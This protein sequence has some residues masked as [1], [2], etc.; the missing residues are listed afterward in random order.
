MRKTIGGQL[1]HERKNKKTSRFIW[2]SYASSSG[3]EDFVPLLPR[4]G[5]TEIVIKES[6]V[7]V[8]LGTI[9]VPHLK[10]KQKKTFS[11]MSLS[12]PPS[13]EAKLA[14]YLNAM[15]FVISQGERRG[16]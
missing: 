12:V 6:A 8:G 11:G 9:R 4:R 16:Q 1:R 7:C 13:N 5:V 10:G 15:K 2:P 14:S 3:L